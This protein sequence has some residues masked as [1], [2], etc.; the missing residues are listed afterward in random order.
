[1]TAGDRGIGG[2][3]RRRAARGT[4]VNAAYLVFLNFLGFLKGFAVAAFLTT[5]DYGVWGL[6]AV[7]IVPL[8]DLLRVGI[9]DKY[10]QQDEPDQEKAFHLAFTLQ[11]LLSLLFVAAL[12]LL[13]PLYALAYGEWSIVLPGYV[14]ALAI[15][16]LALQAPLWTFYRRM[17]FVQQRKLQSFDPI[18]GLVVTIGLAA[19]G[20]G[21]WSLVAGVVCGSW[22]AAIAAL[23]AS[24]YPLKLRYERGKLREYA[25]FSGPLMFGAFSA[26][27]LAQ[28]PAIVAQRTLGLAAIGAIAIATTISNYASRVDD[29][30]TETLY[31]AICAVKD[32]AELLKESFVKSNRLAILWAMPLGVALTLFGPD[33]VKY[34]LGSEWAIAIFAI[35]AYGL[36]AAINQVGF[37]WSAFYRAIGNTRPIAVTS[38]VMLVAVLGLAVPGLLVDGVRGFSIGMGLAVLCLVAMRVHYLGRLFGVR[39]VLVNS[40]RGALPVLPAT[41]LV[42]LVRYGIEGTERAWADV[43]GELAVF[44]I[45]VTAATLFSERSLLREF[46]GYF[47]RPTSPVAAA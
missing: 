41:A 1:M 3:L 45:A 5:G 42:L 43:I 18:I 35:Q 21:Y 7:T 31:P 27:V 9:D 33:L 40:L 12:V 10:I 17:D 44:G 30:V 32:R 16:A 47:S 4:V 20:A 28:V 36:T 6:L 37:N 15:P 19:A 29:V 34:V 8:L 13:L 11:L 14:V 26:I 23:R 38:V 22:A 2:D 39:A 24:T 25:N 46:R